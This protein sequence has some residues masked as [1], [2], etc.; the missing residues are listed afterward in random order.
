MLGDRPDGN[1][2]K[3]E[4]LTPAQ[5]CWQNPVGLRCR[6]NENNV[7]GRLF[8]CL[9]E[10]VEGLLGQHVDLIDDVDLISA[11]DWGESHILS[12]FADLIDAVIARS[13]DFEHVE[14]DS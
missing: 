9:Q 14:A 10:S 2:P 7:V 13:I 3:I 8:Q 12:Q 11:T 6:K 1:P 5:D 4:S